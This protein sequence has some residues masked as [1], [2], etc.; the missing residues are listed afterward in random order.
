MAMTS[1][2]AFIWEPSFRLAPCELI[3]GPLGELDHHIVHRRLEAGV[4][5]AGH[6]VLDLV[7]GITQG[8]LGW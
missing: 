3:K 5:F 6:V 4:G 2:V 1:P 7:Q 8:D